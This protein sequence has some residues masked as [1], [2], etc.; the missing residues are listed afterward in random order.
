MFWK[1]NQRMSWKHLQTISVER[2][3]GVQRRHD[4]D[5]GLKLALAPRGSKG[6]QQGRLKGVCG[7]LERALLLF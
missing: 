3:S 4:H 5:R 1:A 6:Q 7:R 2:L